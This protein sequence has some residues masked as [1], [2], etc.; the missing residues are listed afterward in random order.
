MGILGTAIL[1][2]MGDVGKGRF[3]ERLIE[4]LTALKQRMDEIGEQKIDHDYIVSEEFQSVLFDA[5]DQLKASHD[6]SKIHLLASALASCATV[7][8]SGEQRKE[9]FVWLVRDLTPFHLRQLRDLASEAP[10]LQ[11]FPPEV[12]WANRVTVKAPTGE[13]LMILQQLAGEGLVEE[14]LES[15]PLPHAPHAVSS[16][17]EAADYVD[18]LLKSLAHPPRRCF[19]LTRFGRDFIDFVKL[20][21][22]SQEQGDDEKEKSNQDRFTNS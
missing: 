20:V 3:R 15:P 4:L 17:R 2:A 13:A 19:R 1:A 6:R 11:G 8:F 22:K 10:R 21:G 16:P 12:Q 14:E 18:D 5:F 7:E 9:L